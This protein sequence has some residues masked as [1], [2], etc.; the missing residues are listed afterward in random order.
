MRRLNGH[1]GRPGSGDPLHSRSGSP[2]VG[3]GGERR[4]IDLAR[5]IL[6]GE[7]EAGRGGAVSGAA[8]AIR[9][10]LA[11]RIAKNRGVS[12]SDGS[13]ISF[14]SIADVGVLEDD[15]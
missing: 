7:N 13:R 4:E 10:S 6:R 8:Q 15:A 12:L 9:S 2:T 14:A 1:D 11:A 3:G 5:I